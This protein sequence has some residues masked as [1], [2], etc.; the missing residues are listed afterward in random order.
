M[1][2]VSVPDSCPAGCLHV[3]DPLR[4]RL[5]Y[6]CHAS[7]LRCHL[8]SLSHNSDFCFFKN[9]VVF[10][11]SR[12]LRVCV[13]LPS[14]CSRQSQLPTRIDPKLFWILSQ[15]TKIPMETLIILNV[16]DR[17]SKLVQFILFPNF[18]L[19]SRRWPQGLPQDTVSNQENCFLPN[20]EARWVIR[21]ENM[22][23]L[24]F[25]H[26]S[27]KYHSKKEKKNYLRPVKVVM[28]RKGN[29]TIQMFL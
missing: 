4:S 1:L 15:V 9:P 8:L 16:T 17:F 6:W 20:S 14:L 13:S 2:K 3:P 23:R 28:N 29:M 27:T 18:Y 7:P 26:P 5:L 25:S 24:M 21:W 12:W 10:T 19:L 22:K 11:L